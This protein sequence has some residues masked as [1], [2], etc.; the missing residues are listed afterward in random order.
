MKGVPKKNPYLVQKQQA[1]GTFHVQ[2][3]T[4]AHFNK[5]ANREEEKHY[6]HFQAGKHEVN[7]LSLASEKLAKF[8]KQI[9][10]HPQGAL[11]PRGNHVTDEWLQTV[12]H[13]C[14]CDSLN[15]T[16]LNL[17]NS[18]GPLL[19]TL[20]Q[21]LETIQTAPTRAKY[22]FFITK[23]ERVAKEIED[24]ISF[25]NIQHQFAKGTAKTYDSEVVVPGATA[26]EKHLYIIN[27]FTTCKNNLTLLAT[28]A[29]N[30]KNDLMAT[31]QPVPTTVGNAT[32]KW[33][34]RSIQAQQDQAEIDSQ[35]AEINRR[36]AEKKAFEENERRV[37]AARQER[38]QD[39]I[40]QREKRVWEERHLKYL[41]KLI[42]DP[43][44][45]GRKL[46][47]QE[48]GLQFE[49]ENTFLKYP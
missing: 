28:K 46:E 39:S 6:A 15:R 26:D 31:Y 35:I 36:C 49:L 9:T 16:Y 8:C 30:D 7:A 44:D 13:E 11:E 1:A 14:G 42:A 29:T 20:A 25:R 19:K 12:F 40:N 33:D 43:W 5:R 17:W 37:L 21:E 38:L 32:G 4:G 48:R 18:D 34:F 23:V 22:Q 10:D 45:R 3:T 2:M 27:L 41:T 24:V 47:R